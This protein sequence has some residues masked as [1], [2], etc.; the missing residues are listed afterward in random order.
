M[1]GKLKRDVAV[2]P[3]L[4]RPGEDFAVGHVLVAAA[5]DEAAPRD[6]DGQVGVGADQV[7]LAACRP[8]NPPGSAACA[9]P[10]A[11]RRRDR[12]GRTGRRRRRSPRTPP[13]TCRRPGRALRWGD[14]VTFQ[15]SAPLALRSMKVCDERAPGLG[16][17]RLFGRIGVRQLAGVGL[18][19]DRDPHVERL[20]DLLQHGRDVA[21]LV[22]VGVLVEDRVHA[23]QA[24]DRRQVAAALHDQ[25]VHFVDQ[26]RGRRR[27]GQ[28]DLVAGLD[29]NRVVRR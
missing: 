5:V 18:A 8:A 13:T 2:D 29:A 21:Q 22:V 11:R 25:L 15:R 24:D 26:R 10:P 3:G 6:A 27:G 23:G 9:R 12:A 14:S 19:A 1:A 17:P 4:L 7:D 28:E 20:D 16:V